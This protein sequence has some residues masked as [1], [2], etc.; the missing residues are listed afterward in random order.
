MSAEQV[1]PQRLAEHH[2]KEA[3]RLLAKRWDVITTVIKAGA[4]ASLAVYYATQAGQ[5][6]LSTPRN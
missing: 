2:A 4:H 6:P 1:D 3:E 5:K